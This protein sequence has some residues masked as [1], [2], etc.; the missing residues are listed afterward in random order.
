MGLSITIYV[1]NSLGFPHVT[2][3]CESIYQLN[4]HKLNEYQFNTASSLIQWMGKT[5]C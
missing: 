5:Q 1:K 4:G 3:L 2:Q